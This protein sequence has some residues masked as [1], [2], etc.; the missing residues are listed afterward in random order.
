M[1]RFWCEPAAARHFRVGENPGP[2][3]EVKVFYSSIKNTALGL[4]IGWSKRCSVYCFGGNVFAAQTSGIV[5]EF[6]EAEEVMTQELTLA[7][8]ELDLILELLEGEQKSLL[9]EIRHTDTAVFRAGL[10]D[11]LAMVESLIQ[12]AE[13]LIHAEQLGLGKRS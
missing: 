13:A 7:R 9:V 2:Q 10:K 4:P 6:P 3:E 5:F 12:R 11:R 1:S 8:P